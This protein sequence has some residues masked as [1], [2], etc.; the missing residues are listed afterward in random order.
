MAFSFGTQG[1]TP[2]ASNPLSAGTLNLSGSTPQAK[3]LSS[4]TQS[5]FSQNPV[6]GKSS[7]ASTPV[8][9]T[10]TANTQSFNPATVGTFNTTPQPAT[11]GL[12]H[13]TPTTPVKSQTTNNVDGSS[14]TTT[15]H[16]PDTAT[17]APATAQNE[18]STTAPVGTSNGTS[19]NPFPGIVNNLANTSTQGSLQGQ[20]ATSNLADTSQQGS[21]Q[22]QQITG[23]LQNASNTSSPVATAA[24]QATAQAGFLNPA[25]ATNAQ[26]I[27][28]QYSTEMNNLVNE[29]GPAVSGNTT[30]GGGPIGLGRAGAIEAN[31][32][33]QLQGEAAAGNFALGAN[34]QGLTAAQQQASAEAAAG[35]L[36]NTQQGLIQSGL[37]SAGGLANTAQQNKQSGLESAGNLANTA[38]ANTQSGLNSAGNLSYPTTLALGQYQTNPTTGLPVGG[39]VG[40]A[41]Q[42]ATTAGIINNNIQQGNQFSDSASAVSNTLNTVS[43]L[44]PQIANFMQANN[45]NTGANAPILT[46]PINTYLQSVGNPGA[47]SAWNTYANELN[48]LAG[49]LTQAKGVTPTG[50]EAQTLSQNPA[51]LNYSQLQTYL[52][53]LSNVGQTYQAQQANSAS[54]AYGS[55]STPGTPYTGGNAATSPTPTTPIATPNVGASQPPLVQAGAGTILGFLGGAQALAAGAGSVITKILEFL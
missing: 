4:A 9:K 12:L 42:N 2:G 55:N 39:G 34:A 28:N 30:G 10:L 25:L 23:Q 35:G 13:Q 51:A 41:A 18:T 31:V 46:T 49:Q 5:T 20:A 47:I 53:A 43:Q 32:G 6:V 8:A 40:Q 17:I 29:E 45:I 22:G 36:A 1:A 24:Q 54:Q 11:P 37:E 50:A 27:G 15:Y 33:Q 19:G 26:Q 21:A 3:A 7:A 44:G 14:N 48:N 52:Q 16:A 38:Q